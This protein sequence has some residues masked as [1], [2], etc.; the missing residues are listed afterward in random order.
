MIAATPHRFTRRTVTSLF[1]VSAAVGSRVP[2]VGGQPLTTG[3]T[4][5]VEPASD[6]LAEAR[7]STSGW[8]TDFGRHT[9][10]LSEITSGGPPP[11]GIPPIDAPTFV[12]IDEA[13]DW[14]VAHEPV[15]A[16][17]VL[18]ADGTPASVGKA[19]PLQ[20]LIWHEIVNDLLDGV[21]LLVTFCPLCN[22]S[23]VF[24]RR[25]HPDEPDATVYDFGTTGNLRHSD[26]VMWDRQTESWWQQVS[27]EAIVG[28]LAGSVLTSIPSQLISF[29]QFRESWPEGEVLS[30]ATG[31]DRPYGDN[32]YPGY[33]DIDSSPF[34]FDQE[35]DDRLPAMQRVI[36]VT[37]DDAAAAWPIAD[38]DPAQVINDEIADMPI[39]VITTEGAA[40]ALDAS[41][42][43][44][45]RDVGQSGVFRRDLDD[46]VLTFAFSGDGTMMDEE[47][48]SSWSLTG[49][50]MDGPLAGS[51][52]RPIAHVIVFWFAWAAFQPETRIFELD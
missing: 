39:V 45:G 50:A 43:S 7:F 11:D 52:L 21:P 40:S 23:I 2:T 35:A 18:D 36:G 42:I 29:A 49:E 37:L 30:R 1:L 4:P 19:Y 20:I 14:L 10:P 15:I 44:S 34:L 51:Q 24:D 3:A 12:A 27:G 32:P 16:L 8:N 22:T 6:A 47:T 46:R 25:L 38:D 5:T 26:L 28:E 17:G 31:F 13:S 33:D 41:Q 48:G 9:V